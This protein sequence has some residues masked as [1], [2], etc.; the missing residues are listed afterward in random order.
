MYKKF[1]GNDFNQSYEDLLYININDVYDFFLVD[2]D[3]R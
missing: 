1:L 2:G 3:I